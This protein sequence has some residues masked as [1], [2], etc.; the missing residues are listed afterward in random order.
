MIRLAFYLFA[1]LVSVLVAVAGCSGA[2]RVDGLDPSTLPPEI[3][4]DYEVFAH[5]CSKCHTLAR[6]LDAPIT[7]DE[8]WRIY[9]KRMQRMPGSGITD[10]DAA[11]ILRF[12]H[13][14][15]AEQRTKKGAP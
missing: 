7:S 13:H 3:R 6:P 11:R 1:S 5:R 9:V 10:A 8:F 2:R 4:A 12:L 15:A 14:H